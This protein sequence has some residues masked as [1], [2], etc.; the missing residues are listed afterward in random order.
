MVLVAVVVVVLARLSSNEISVSGLVQNVNRWST[1]DGSS[2]LPF[3]R[4]V[5]NYASFFFGKNCTTMLLRAGLKSINK[6]VLTHLKSVGYL[7]TI[8]TYKKHIGKLRRGRGG[9][10]VRQMERDCLKYIFLRYFTP[11]NLNFIYI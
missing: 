10:R 2:A 6:L 8:E 11:E 4:I 3:I 5:Q 1:L 7:L 9:L